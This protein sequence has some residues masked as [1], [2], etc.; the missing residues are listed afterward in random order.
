MAHAIFILFF[1]ALGACI[2]SFLNVVVWRLPRGESLITPPSHCPKCN[3]P[4]RWYDNL[5][6]IGWIKLGGRCRYC[7]EPISPRYPIVEAITGALFAFYYVMFFMLNIG[8]CAEVR[9][10]MEAGMIV[11][12]AHVRLDL[13]MHWPIYI[14]YMVL[15]SA[16][17]AASLIDAE[18]FIIPVEI[19]WVLAAVGIMVHAIID[20]PGFPGALNANAQSAAL[21]A[22]GGVGLLIS[23][24]LFYAKIIPM[25][26]PHGEPLL[27]VDRTELI[28]E[29]EQARREGK[30]H[31]Q[32]DL[33]PPPYTKKDIRREIRKEMLFLMPPMLLAAAWW[34]LTMRVSAIGGLWA[35]ATSYHW[36]TGLL[37]SVL[38]ALVGAFVV[39][40]TRILGTLGFGRVAM[41]LGDVHLMFGVGA[42]VGAGA[43]TVAFFLAP[44]FGIVLAI[45]ML[46]TGTRRELP[47]GPYLSLATAFGLLFYC[48]IARYL[49]P[50][51]QG[52]VIV[53]RNLLS[54]GSAL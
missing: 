34:V 46:L 42:I 14:L 39:W 17:L 45:Y 21:A 5:P 3:T 36:V 38:G 12:T 49:S 32:A 33:V 53:V 28:K 19:C 22:G 8:P 23:I 10:M 1:F 47:Y 41:G 20:Q 29:I 25:S 27:E 30:D 26:F 54:G 50:G 2:G 13:A 6:V 37:G 31:P 52:L 51:M 44:F 40:I 9:R 24:A 16:L 4:L 7:K 15:I 11:V 18:L 43:A 35:S 48:E